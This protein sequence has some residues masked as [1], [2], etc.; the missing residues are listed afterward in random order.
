M[1]LFGFNEIILILS[2]EKSLSQMTKEC[3]FIMK[4]NTVALK[5]KH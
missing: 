4:A 1:P 2:F 3:L 5:A